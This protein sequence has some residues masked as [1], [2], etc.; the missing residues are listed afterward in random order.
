MVF[1]V[2]AQADQPLI[3]SRGTA[4]DMAKA[5][6]ARTFRYAVIKQDLKSIL[7]EF[8]YIMNVQVDVSPKIRGYVEN[9]SF[10]A[11]AH[12]VLQSISRDYAV[13]WYYDGATLYFTSEDEAITRL[14]PM[15]GISPYRLRDELSHLGLYDG[16]YTFRFSPESRMVLVAGPPRYVSTIEAAMTTLT[17][18]SNQR[19][20]TIIRGGR[21][22]EG[23]VVP[24]QK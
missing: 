24:L 15:S 14:I 1:F 6:H 5:W 17:D 10:S 20:F 11:S 4:S 23:F 16:R 22:E 7:E 3:D 21:I 19:P 18:R 12:N 2:P 8:G 9:K 13:Q